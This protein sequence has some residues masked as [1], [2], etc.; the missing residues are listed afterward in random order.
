MEK[1]TFGEP[2]LKVEQKDKSPKKVFILGVYASAVHA[3]WLSIEGKIL[4]NALAVASEPEIFWR[5]ENAQDI[6]SRIKIAEETCKLIP[7]DN[8]FNGP[9]GRTLDEE[10][11]KPLG[12]SLDKCW[13]CDLVSH[14]MINPNQVKAIKRNK[15]YFQEYKLKRYNMTSAA[16]KNR[17]IDSA[18]QAEIVSEIKK[19]KAEY[20]ITLGD[21]PLI[22]FVK[23]LNP[24]IGRLNKIENNCIISLQVK[25]EEF[26]QV[27]L[28]NIDP[29]T[30]FRSL[31]GVAS[32]KLSSLTPIQPI[33][34]ISRTDKRFVDSYNVADQLDNTTNIAAM[35]WEDFEHLIREL[36]E[37]EFKSN[38]GEVK[39][40]QASRDGGVD[41]VAFDPDPIRGGK[42]VI[43]A[44]R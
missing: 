35:D 38:G 29:K 9:S 22:N 12:L 17:K 13:L 37:K 16:I 11:L 15:A 10:Y 36:F 18:R 8:K 34:Q 7:A 25:K 41:A 32:S 39:V 20:L 43:Q 27:D 23:K 28:A 5:G 31:K 24:F 4:I 40:T 30:C 21:E 26:I 6:I 44:K 14:S 19:S 42:I 1:F 3:K 33:L 2:V